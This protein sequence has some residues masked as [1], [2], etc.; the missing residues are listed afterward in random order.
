MKKI[1]VLAGNYQEF[2]HHFGRSPNEGGS[3]YI[4]ADRPDRIRGVKAEKIEVVGTFWERKDAR[5]M[6]DL[7]MTRVIS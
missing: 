5:D 4:Y 2:M 7:A 1:L 6:Y 3:E